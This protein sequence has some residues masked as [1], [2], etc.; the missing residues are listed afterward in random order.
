MRLDFYKPI[1]EGIIHE[2]ISFHIDQKP[3]SVVNNSSISRKEKSD[4]VS[5]GYCM[6]IIW[7]RARSRRDQKMMGSCHAKSPKRRIT[8]ITSIGIELLSIPFFVWSSHVCPHC[9]N[10]QRTL[11]YW[12]FFSIYR[13]AT[14]WRSRFLLLSR[15][16]RDRRLSLSGTM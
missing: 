10:L 9:Q 15:S 12:A 16:A 5:W 13:E 1:F 11:M 6:T 14:S 7:S 2:N 4:T 3:V 8:S